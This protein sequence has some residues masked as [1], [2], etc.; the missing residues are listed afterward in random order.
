MFINKMTK[1]RLVSGS[2]FRLL[3][4][5]QLRDFLA[6]NFLILLKIYSIN[7]VTVRLVDAFTKLDQVSKLSLEPCLLFNT[8]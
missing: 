3:S 6:L 8:F 7:V 2:S 1:R 4:T 5:S